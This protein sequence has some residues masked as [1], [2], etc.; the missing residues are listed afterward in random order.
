MIYSGLSE[1]EVIDLQ[2]KY[3]KNVLPIKDTFSRWQIF[4]SQFKSPLI[5]ILFFVGLFSIIF[6]EFFDAILIAMVINLD[7]FMG[8]FQEL[9]SQK[10][11]TSLRNIL[12]PTALVIR[13]G[14]R[15]EI[16]ISELVPGDIVALNAGDKIPAD[17][18]LL[19]TIKML[20]DES[21]LTGES[22]A[23][24]KSCYV[25]KKSIYMGTTV[26][27]GKGIMKV[28]KIGIQTEMGKIGKSLS[29]IKDEKTPL[30]EKLE[31]FSKQLVKIIIIICSVLFFVELFFHA[32]FFEALRMAIIL[33]VAAIP[34]GLPIAV[35]VILAIG[36]RRILKKHGLV[37]KLLSIETLGSTSVVC[38][39][40]TGTLTEGKMKVVKT[41]FK[42]EIKA[43]LSMILANEQRD[44]LE[45]A[46]WDY[47]KKKGQINPEKILN[48]VKK[49]YEDP[50]DSTKKYSLTVIKSGQK[51]TA[52][53]LGAPE[54]VLS[55]CKVSKEEKKEIL[56]KIEVMAGS[57][58]KVLGTAYKETGNLK[59]TVEFN[60]IGLSAIEDPLRPGAGETIKTAISAG[61][62]IKIITGD[63]KKTAEE[64][65]RQLGFLVTSKNSIEGI[66]LEKMSDTYLSKNVENFIV[67]SRITPQQKLRIV[68]ALQENGEV[69][70]MTGDG[71]NDA[72]ALKKADIGVVVGT[73]TEVAKEAGDLILLDGNFKTIILA[74]EEGRRIFAN[75]KKVVA[76][77]LSNSFVEIFLIIGA[78]ML[79]T[80]APLTIIQI[81]WIHLICDGPPDI[82]LGFEPKEPDIMKQR[83]EMIRSEKILPG[84]MKFLIFAL[85]F[86]IGGSALLLFNYFSLTK[87]LVF[88]RTIVFASV[89]MVDLI[90]IFSF[91]NLSKPLFKTGKF[92]ENK[93]LLL[94]VLYGFVL[95][96][97]AV[98]VP[99]FNKILGTVPLGL[100]HWFIVL[101]VGIFATVIVEINKFFTSHSSKI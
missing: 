99:L 52:F 21:I 89:A 2:K 23:V 85:S 88:A 83:P 11:L 39:D 62:K 79:K 63:Y 60:W 50:F 92:F 19:E 35:T 73:A 75:I 66:D 46:L 45:I 84:R 80:P 43:Q 10:T 8:Y 36:M 69:V 71:V 74:I 68:K 15:R 16:S 4:F 20:V 9:S 57:G 24:I 6:G 101:S 5:Y 30:Q 31:L 34:E 59:K 25:S 41:D 44:S 72:P 27:F 64:I 97:I 55:F 61:I 100:T 37:K 38:T 49:T 58:L 33:S 82:A 17:G 94:S 48:S 28:E 54:V 95:I 67:F 81:L 77:V 7:V 42:D 29:E 93:V 76:Y 26:L 78:V 14:I 98:Y 40:K 18:I 22:K 13:N 87:D 91:K 96:L 12:E 1:R 86:I 51:E 32:D 65:A 47:V 90:Y 56:N 70:A 3:G 53:I